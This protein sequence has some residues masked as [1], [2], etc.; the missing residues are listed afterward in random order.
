MTNSIALILA[1]LITGFVVTDLYVMDWGAVPFLFRKLVAFI[2]Y[3]AF[4]R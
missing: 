2:E 1:I 3:L 4:W